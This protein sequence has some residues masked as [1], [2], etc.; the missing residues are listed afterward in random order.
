MVESTIARNMGLREDGVG[1]LVYIFLIKV[2]KVEIEKQ[3]RLCCREKI[4]F[5]TWVR[6]MFCLKLGQERCGGE[7]EKKRV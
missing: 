7:L 3:R 6:V 1:L 4:D 5:R 2:R